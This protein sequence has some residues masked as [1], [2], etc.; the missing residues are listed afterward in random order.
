M[1]ILAW[2]KGK[3]LSYQWASGKV[4]FELSTV[5]EETQLYFCD[6]LPEEFPHQSR[7][8]TGWALTLE[9]LSYALLGK[10]TEYN[11]Q[12]HKELEKEY[13]AKIDLLKLSLNCTN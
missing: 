5:E 9:R 8:I 13:Q 1:P 3:L 10:T 4:L 11:M 6:S 7:D 12:K 2:E